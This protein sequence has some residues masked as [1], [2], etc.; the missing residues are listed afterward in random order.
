LVDEIKDDERINLPS[1][2]SFHFISL[3]GYERMID[4]NEMMV[5]DEMKKYDH[6]LMMGDGDISSSSSSSSS[7]SLISSHKLKK[8]GLEP[9]QVKNR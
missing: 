3:I 2:I 8:R 6:Q 7:S 4:N 1:T 9:F 5:D